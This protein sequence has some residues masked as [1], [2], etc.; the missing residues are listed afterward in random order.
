MSPQAVVDRFVKPELREQLD[1]RITEIA[2]ICS[3]GSTKSK[4]LNF[5]KEVHGWNPALPI[6]RRSPKE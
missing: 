1:A 3:S 5:E 6:W 2:E 4:V